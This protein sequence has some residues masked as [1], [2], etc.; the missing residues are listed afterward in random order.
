MLFNMIFWL[1]CES[2]NGLLNCNAAALPARSSCVTALQVALCSVLATVF[3][4]SRLRHYDATN[5]VRL[6]HCAIQQCNSI[7]AVRCCPVLRF[8]SLAAAASPLL[9]LLLSLLPLQ[10]LPVVLG[11]RQ[12][13]ARLEMFRQ[14]TKQ[15]HPVAEVTACTLV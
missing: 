5:V 1:W 9:L 14:L 6:H 12:Y 3:S 10:I 8:C 4:S 7:A 15:L 13:S 2:C 11:V